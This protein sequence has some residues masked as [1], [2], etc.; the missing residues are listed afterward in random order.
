MANDGCLWLT[1]FHDWSSAIGN[2]IRSY[3]KLSV[4]EYL[5]VNNAIHYPSKLLSRKVMIFSS[6]HL[7]QTLLQVIQLVL[8]FFLM[9]I[10]MTYNGYLCI[11][12]ALGSMFG[13][14]IFSWSNGR[15]DSCCS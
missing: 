9:F 15:C 5:N 3:K 10:F 12:V 6:V 13:Y 4:R 11:A 2:D 7:L 14:F 8:G 1:W